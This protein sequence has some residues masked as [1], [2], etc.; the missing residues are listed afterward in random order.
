MKRSFILNSKLDNQPICTVVI[1]AFN[2]EQFIADCLASIESQVTDYKIRVLVHDDCSTDGTLRVVNSFAKRSKFEYKV[3]RASENQ[4]TQGFNFFYRLLADCESKYIAI[5]DSD[6]VWTVPDKLETQ[7]RLLEEH[8]NLAISSHSFTTFSD[9]FE[10]ESITW[11]NTEFRKPVMNYEDLAKENFIGA[12]TV[13]FRRTCLPDG[14]VGFNRLGT[15]DYPLWGVISGR[16]D[17]GFIDRVMAKYRVHSNQYFNTKSI[18]DKQF[19][20]LESKIFVASNSEGHV[21]RAWINAVKEDIVRQYLQLNSPDHAQL[22]DHS[23]VCASGIHS[24]KVSQ[25]EQQIIH[26][27]ERAQ[28]SETRLE[29]IHASWSWRLT[30]PLRLII[31]FIQSLFRFFR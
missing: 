6:D 29:S 17:I 24:S 8:P 7:I 20:N 27:I 3:I 18:E 5:L 25:L 12:L 2:S 10:I 4:F 15:G 19:V 28:Y 1:L 21:K 31:M 26:L 14:L 30:R 9:S 22:I 13:V 11:P 16:G 23:E